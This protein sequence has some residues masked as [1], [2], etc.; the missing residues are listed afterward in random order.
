MVKYDAYEKQIGALFAHQSD[1]QVKLDEL[2]DKI[3]ALTGQN[4]TMTDFNAD[5]DALKATFKRIS[6]ENYDM[7]RQLQD[8]RFTYLEKRINDTSVTVK[9]YTNKLDNLNFTI[10]GLRA[11][12]TKIG[13]LS[14]AIR[15]ART[16]N[17]DLQDELVALLKE[18]KTLSVSLDR[19]IVI[20]NQRNGGQLLIG[21][22]A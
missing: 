5:L 13:D 1:Y 18:S 22:H 19:S 17:K 4:K 15:D 11:D 14:G 6:E 10:S 3:N 12:L 20:R 7:D 9:M 16:K 21:D 2:N 8:D